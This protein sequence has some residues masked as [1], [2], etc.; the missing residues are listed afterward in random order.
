MLIGSDRIYLREEVL[1]LVIECER[2]TP[3]RASGLLR[4]NTDSPVNSN[5]C[6]S[7]KVG[8]DTSDRDGVRQTNLFMF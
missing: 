3:K 2:M 8:E 1:I 7:F 5:V 4:L 6:V